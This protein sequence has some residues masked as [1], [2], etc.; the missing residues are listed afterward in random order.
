MLVFLSLHLNMNLPLQLRSTPK[1]HRRPRRLLH[2]RRRH[3]QRP[4][5]RTLQRRREYHQRGTRSFL[6]IVVSQVTATHSNVRNDDNK[7][8]ASFHRLRLFIT[9]RLAPTVAPATIHQLCL[10]AFRSH[11]CLD[12]YPL[13]FLLDHKA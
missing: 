12:L 5:N 3:R 4:R 13:L 9:I 2:R 1:D 10:L 11:P 7:N 6:T 8:K